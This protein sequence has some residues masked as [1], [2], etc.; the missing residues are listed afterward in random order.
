MWAV[1]SPPGRWVG[2]PGSASPSCSAEMGSCTT[3]ERGSSLPLCF[4]E[5]HS[6]YGAS[7]GRDLERS[8]SSA[9]LENYL[10]LHYLLREFFLKV[11]RIACS[12]LLLCSVVLLVRRSALSLMGI[13]E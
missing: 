3:E 8:P 2:A 6:S 12:S 10:S 4:A 11:N 9:R 13:T 5:H 7:A 1:V